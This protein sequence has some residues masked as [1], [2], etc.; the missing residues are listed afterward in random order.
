MALPTFAKRRL[1]Y[2]G[3]FRVLTIQTDSDGT[4]DSFPLPIR[5][6]TVTD[7][8]L[9]ALTFTPLTLTAASSNPRITTSN[10]NGTSITIDGGIAD[11]LHL[12]RAWSW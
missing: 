10:A 9:R 5:G 1:S 3:P 6:N 7:T 12:I 4:A 11:D 8:Q 2:M